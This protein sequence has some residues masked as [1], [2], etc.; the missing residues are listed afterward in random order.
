MRVMKTQTIK[1]LMSKMERARRKWARRM[2]EEVK[3]PSQRV[4][5]AQAILIV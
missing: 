4:S 2:T 5:V 3:M 1:M